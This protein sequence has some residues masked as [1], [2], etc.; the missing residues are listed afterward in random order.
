M[1]QVGY[2]RH[3]LDSAK[4]RRLNAICYHYY[5]MELVWFRLGDVN[6]KDKIIDG[7][8]LVNGKW[9]NKTVKIP[10]LINNTP[11]KQQEYLDVIKFLEE[12]SYMLFQRYGSK[13]LTNDYLKEDDVFC[14]LI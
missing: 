7:K 11:Y 4:T 12:N 3:P 2:F 14:H 9:K 5:G 1:Q 10:K 13:K 6:M 8:V